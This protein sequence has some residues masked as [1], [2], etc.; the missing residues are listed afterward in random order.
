ME[1]TL[2][3]GDFILCL[4]ARA[5]RPGLVYWVRHPRFGDIVKRLHADGT[6]RS[7]GP[8]GRDSFQLGAIADCEVLGRAVL[9]VR[10]SGLTRLRA[11]R[12]YSRR[13]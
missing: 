9:A 8:E 12:P 6:L 3:D 10:R 4:K 5:P 11:P 13:A 7:D 2:A 1:P